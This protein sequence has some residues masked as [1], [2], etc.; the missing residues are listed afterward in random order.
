MVTPGGRL[1]R[2]A[3]SHGGGGAPVLPQ[4]QEEAEE[5]QL[6]VAEPPVASAC[7]GRRW[8]RRIDDGGASA[9]DSARARGAMQGGGTQAR[10]AAQWA[11]ARVRLD[12]HLN[13]H[14]GSAPGVRHACRGGGGGAGKVGLGLRWPM[15]L[16]GPAAG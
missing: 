8:P 10:K 16:A 11:R 7:T 15:G 2:R 1:G 5:A 6:D 9:G 12:L 14:V 4:P 13:R 3:R